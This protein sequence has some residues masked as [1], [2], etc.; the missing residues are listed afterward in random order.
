MRGKFL[1][2]RFSDF[3]SNSFLIFYL[4]S[5]YRFK[6]FTEKQI[7]DYQKSKLNIVTDYAFRHSKFFNAL[8]S[9]CDINAFE[10]LPI[11]S[12]KTM[13][14]NL[15]DYNTLGLT[16]EKILDFCLEIEKS[17]DYSKRLDGINIGMSSGTSGNKGV[18][19][20]T[21]REEMYMKAALLARFD[22][23]KG[24]KM[25]VA[26]ILRVSAPAFSLGILGHR[27]TYVSQLNSIEN[28]S[29][30]LQDI[31][32]NI[33]SAPP[34]MLKLIAKEVEEKRLNI[35]PKRLI[36]Y[37]EIIYPDVRNYL[38]EVFNCP[39]HEIY[40]C[41]EGPIAM[42]CKHER[43]HINEDLVFVETFN[44]DGSKTI[45]GNPCEK[46]VITD[47]HKRAQPIIRYH[48]NDIIT[49]S[50]K[51]CECG[52]NFRVI[53]NIQGRSDD[54]LWGRKINR[55]SMQFIFPD[56]IT[57]AIITSS[58]NIDEYQVVQTSPQDMTIKI[59]LK[60]KAQEKN[61]ERDVLIKNMENLFVE[62][63]CEKPRIE[64]KF[65]KPEAN[66]NSNKLARIQRNF[67]IKEQN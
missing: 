14:E 58:E 51:K 26:F 47:L 21:P 48:L 42:T 39:L 30:R 13:M 6:H 20:V 65:E 23:P 36:T 19:I 55:D 12:K 33:L 29:S 46:L 24:E 31:N 27:L 62:Y 25:N 4:L 22:I 7:K 17:R 49:V 63:K 43:L 5:R 67:E 50:P 8:Y 32:P 16:K 9:G 52:S 41:T 18:E 66:K 28:I 10:S 38:K 40:K 37:A 11:I 60:D 15:T 59:D 45:P 61:F 53:E 2:D 54:L 56:Y 44:K 3:E 57:R 34:S 35:K 64:I 1:K